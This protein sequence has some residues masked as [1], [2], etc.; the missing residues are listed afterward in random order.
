MTG[1]VPV[2]WLTWGALVVVMIGMK[3]YIGRLSRDE[4]DQLVL[5]DAFN[6]LKTE[7]AASMA[8]ISKIQPIGTATIWLAGA[9]T[10]FVIGYY[11]LD[12]IKQFS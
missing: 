6:N 12:V 9:A 8:R 1:F 2:M 4:N 7:Q 11:V 5:D 10:L 3:M